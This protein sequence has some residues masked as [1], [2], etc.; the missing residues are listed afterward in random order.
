MRILF[1]DT[2]TTGLPKKWDAPMKDLENWP[3]VIQLAWI[4]TDITGIV[5]R[6]QKHLIYPDGWTMPIGNFWIEN[7]FTQSENEMQGIHMAYALDIF[8]SDH[9]YCDI[10][11]SHNMVFDHNVIGAEAY[12]WNRKSMNNPKKICTK[13]VSTDYCKLPGFKGKYKWP[14]LEE[15]HRILFQKDFDNAHDALA[16]VIAMKDCFFELVNRG[17]ITIQP[18]NLESV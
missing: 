9:Q 18:K 10:M 5:I 17:I 3:H 6:K 16:D 12:R 11:V 13:E 4:V 14:K 1:F 15:L 2:E 8:L 7:G